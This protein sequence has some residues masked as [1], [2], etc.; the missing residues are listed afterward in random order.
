ML[1]VILIVVSLLNAFIEFFQ[2]YKTESILEG[3]KSLIPGKCM[4]I[5]D[6][7]QVEIFAIDVVT[8]DILIVRLGDKLPADVRLVVS[9]EIKVDNSSITGESEPQ[10]RSVKAHNIKNPL[11][12]SCLLFSGTLIVQGEGCGIVIRTGS[13]P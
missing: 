10:E 2:Q 9:N 5:R 12:A 7:V 3:F 13:H 6:G 1:G 8:G 4:V 11:E